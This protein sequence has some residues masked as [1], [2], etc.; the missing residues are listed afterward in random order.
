MVDQEDKFYQEV[1]DLSRNNTSQHNVLY[2]RTKLDDLI[3]KVKIAKRVTVKTD[4][5]RHLLKKYD[6]VQ[7]AGIEKLIRK[8]QNGKFC[9]VRPYVRL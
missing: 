8:Q 7:V 4:Q 9:F 3:Q 6:V 5:D 1:L 2:T